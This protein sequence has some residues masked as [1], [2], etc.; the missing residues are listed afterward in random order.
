VPSEAYQLVRE[1]YERFAAGDRDH[2]RGH[3]AQDVEWDTS[4]SESPSARVY[5]GHAGIEEYFRDWLGTWEDFEIELRELVEAGDAVVAVFRNRGRGK[6][7]GVEI[8][9]E[10]YGV[11][12]VRDGTVVRY[13]EFAS[14]EEALT[15]AGRP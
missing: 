8:E 5:R 6:G 2:W 15:A 4:A 10:F 3:L 1:L 7:S 9:R 12:D 11:Y 13:R 14:R